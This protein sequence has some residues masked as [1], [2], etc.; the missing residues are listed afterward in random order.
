MEDHAVR[1]PVV[2]CLD[3]ILSGLAHTSGAATRPCPSPGNP[4]CNGRRSR[5]DAQHLTPPENMLLP[6]L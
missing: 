5:N 4:P 1:S 6:T 3:L 2:C